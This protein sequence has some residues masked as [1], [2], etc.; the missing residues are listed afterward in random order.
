MKILDFQTDAKNSIINNSYQEN[1]NQDIFSN[2]NNLPLNDESLLSF[3]LQSDSE[4][5]AI[6]NFQ[7]NGHKPPRMSMLSKLNLFGLILLTEIAV[8][9]RLGQINFEEAYEKCQ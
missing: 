6:R 4:E 2:N 9:L 1:F 8:M 5:T 7:Q 3:I